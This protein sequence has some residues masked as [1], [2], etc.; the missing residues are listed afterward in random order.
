M[1]YYQK[2]GNNTKSNQ[3]Y[4]ELFLLIKIKLNKKS[5]YK[6]TDHKERIDD[7]P[8]NCQTDYTIKRQIKDF[9]QIEFDPRINNQP[10]KD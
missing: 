3:K 6:K 8:N 1:A 2:N 7:Q 5:D 10:F 9:R 4:G